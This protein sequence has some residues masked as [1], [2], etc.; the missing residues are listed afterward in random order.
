MQDEAINYLEEN[1]KKKPSRC[2]NLAENLC[3]IEEATTA[4]IIYEIPFKLLLG[5]RYI[6]KQI[7]VSKIHHLDDPQ[8]SKTHSS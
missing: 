1:L 5:L 6:D 3:A 2:L 4:L 7:S 8:M